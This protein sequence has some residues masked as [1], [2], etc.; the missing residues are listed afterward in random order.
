MTLG[1]GGN[2]MNELVLKIESIVGSE[3]VLL[4]EPMCNHTSFKIG[5]PAIAVVLPES[6]DGVSGVLQLLENEGIKHYILGN[7][8][9]VLFPDEGYDGIVVKIA[10]RLSNIKID[11]DIVYAE[12]GALLSRVSKLSAKD[13][14]SG[15]EFAS[16]IP[17]TIGGAVVMNAGAYGG[18]MKDVILQTTVVDMKGQVFVYQNEE[19]NFGYRTSVVKDKGYI[20]LSVTMKLKKAESSEIWSKID[21]LNEKRTSRQPLHLPSA[22]STFKRPEGYYAG[23][24]IQDAGLKGLTYGGA[25]VSEKHSGFIVNIDNATYDDVITL[26][27][28]VKKTVKEKFDVDLEPEVKIIERK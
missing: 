28:L 11:G 20:V 5:G 14:L 9:N 3:N 19:M 26:I 23:K 2:K 16:G 15:L 17:G 13:S 10:E 8:T 21:E 27:N 18:E 7:G 12:A 6:V 1:I 22:G 24:L 4:N 25:Q